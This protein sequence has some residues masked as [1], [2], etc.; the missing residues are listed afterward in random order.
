[1][2]TA[3][4]RF[5]ATSLAKNYSFAFVLTEDDNDITIYAEDISNAY[6]GDT[7]E[8]EITR[9]RLGRRYGVIT[10]VITRNKTTFIGTLEWVRKKCYFRCD[11]LKIH[12]L[13]D[14][15]DDQKALKN[16]KVMVEIVNWGIRQ[17]NRLPICNVTEVLG[18]SGEPEVEVLSVIR[19]FNLPLEFPENVI[20]EAHAISHEMSPKEIARR[21]DL[22]TLYTITIDPMS[23]QDFDDAISLIAKSNG[24][25]HLYVHI[26]DVSHYVQTD[27]AIFTEA[28]NRGNSY[29]FPKKVIPMLPEILSNKLCS[30]RPNEDKYTITCLTIFDSKGQIKRQEV[31]ESVICSDIRLSYEEVDEYFEDK[32]TD[33]SRQLKEAID[34]MRDLSQKLSLSR[35]QRGY[36]SFD[37]P[38]VEYIYDDEGYLKNITRTKETESHILIENFMLIANEYVAKLLSQKKRTTMYRIHENP[39]DSDLK[40]LIEILRAYKISVTTDENLNKMWQNL[41]D[42]LPD[43]KHHRVFDMLI[44]RS[45]KKARYSTVNQGHFGLGLSSYTHFT[46]PI[47]RLCDLIVHLQL[48]SIIG[49]G[50][51][52]F[53]AEYL[54]N[55]CKIANEREMVAD[56]SERTVHKK[57]ILSFMAKHVGQTYNAI[58]TNINKNTI[59]VELNDIPVRGVIKLKSLQSDFYQYDER[60]YIVKGRRRGRIFR[61]CD[62]LNVVLASVTD[63]IY[64]DIYDAK[65]AKK[66]RGRK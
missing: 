53:T 21:R 51:V 28:V 37:L 48:K 34:I 15:K 12:T 52:S 49:N 7:V 45:M 8:V 5:D 13:F 1:M 3:I 27:S 42:C 16:A 10:K 22:R 41:L 25:K 54:T 44:L 18:T 57:M 66:R 40:K 20:A 24:E 33:F 35:G 30:L 9:S 6:H 23:A 31:F 36:L 11:N 14:V 61:L 50:S 60:L 17:K 2:N 26:A 39:D 59:F 46:S 43:E 62:P 55:L 56:D 58:I 64:F 65:P 63:D 4:G 38:E 29:Y 47:R 19:D 32:S